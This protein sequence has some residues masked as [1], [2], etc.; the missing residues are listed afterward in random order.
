MTNELIE[1]YLKDS[2]QD[3]SRQP[4]QHATNDQLRTSVEDSRNSNK[5]VVNI[6]KKTPSTDKPAESEP[7][8]AKPPS[9][10]IKKR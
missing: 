8:D 2:A 10:N 5:P 4:Q 1:K 7:V 3:A 9:K 6:A